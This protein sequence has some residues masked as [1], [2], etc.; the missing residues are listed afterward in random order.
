MA[1]MTS[2][3]EYFLW[4]FKRSLRGGPA[5]NSCPA[6]GSSESRIVRRKYGVTALRECENCALRFRTPKDDLGT[7]EAFYSDEVYKQGFTTDLPSDAELQTMLAN[8]FAETEKDFGYRVEALVAAGLKPGA[9]ILDF[10]CSWGYG[11][12]QMRQAGYNVFSYEIGRERARYAEE[13]LQCKMVSDLQTLAGTV[14][15]FFS[16]HVIEHL[17]SP[18]I[19]FDAAESVLRPGGLF[20]CYCP[21]GAVERE[22]RDPDNYHHNWGKV[23][24]LMLT[25]QFLRG[26]A[27][28][29]GFTE[30]AVFSSPVDNND[31]QALREGN[32]EGDELLMTGRLGGGT[33]GLST[34][35]G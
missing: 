16:S 26:E 18:G 33:G 30:C 23:H 32:L 11:S 8:R 1:E 6:C 10:G 35:P 13:K 12:W 31:I 22:K 28:R 7:A 17:A 9:R 19:M 5:A 15:C 34:V 24:P 4:A 21:N 2:R 25:P 3:L 20:V 14:D 29:R 27:G